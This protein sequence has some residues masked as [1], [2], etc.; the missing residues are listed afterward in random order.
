MVSYCTM[1]M[2]PGVHAWT[3]EVEY[4]MFKPDTDANDGFHLATMKWPED[5]P[6]PMSLWCVA[7]FEKRAQMFAESILWRHGL[8]KVSK[9]FVSM[10]IGGGKAQKFPITGPNVFFLENHSK[11]AANVIYT[12]DPAKIR[13]AWEHEMKQA[14]KFFDEHKRWLE[15][16]EGKAIADAFWAKHPGG[17]V[18]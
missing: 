14:Q 8:R 12:N 13:I 17:H 18:E 6:M 11:G 15:T 10:V 7:T 2:R 5:I 4:T 16:E 9:G 1:V 3:V